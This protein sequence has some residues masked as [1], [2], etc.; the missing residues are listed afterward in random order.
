MGETEGRSTQPRTVYERVQL[1][2]KLR[3]CSPR[4]RTEKTVRFSFRSQLRTFLF[5][6]SRWLRRYSRVY[7]IFTSTF[8]RG[9]F[10]TFLSVIYHTPRRRGQLSRRRFSLSLRR[11][12]TKL[13]N[14]L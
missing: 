2:R 4:I 9:R 10:E 1:N 13:A 3:A 12:G 5:G 14:K 7:I 8:E 11:K 6:I